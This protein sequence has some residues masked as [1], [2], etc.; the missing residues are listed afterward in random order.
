MKQ[1]NGFTIVELLVVIVVIAILATVTVVAFNGVRD[2][3]AASLV[4]DGISKVSRQLELDKVSRGAYADNL[5]QVNATEVN[6]LSYQY[7]T[8]GSTY[9]LTATSGNISKYKQSDGSTADG[10]CSGHNDPNSPPPEVEVVA[11]SMAEIRTPGQTTPISQ[12]HAIPGELSPSD[13]VFVIYNLDFYS[14]VHGV[15]AGGVQFNQA[16]RKTM[17]SA[18]YQ[19]TVAYSGTGLSG[20]LTLQTL[21]CY[22]GNSTTSC[23]SGADVRA[24]YMVFVIKGKSSPLTVTTTDTSYGSQSAGTTLT[25]AVAAVDSGDIAFFVYTYYGNNLPVLSDASSPAATWV[26]ASERS[27]AT[28]RPGATSGTALAISHLEASATGTVGRSL[29][30]PGSGAVYSGATL[31]VLK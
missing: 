10:V 2:R 3:A 28:A 14:H 8:D 22:G 7:T 26:V 1:K 11:S 17:G 18:G 25:P 4:Q 12:A 5:T 29:T 23:Y 27:G 9:C 30:M 20:Q 31:F 16:Y 21:A 24:E 19:Q 15:S 13:T 6:S